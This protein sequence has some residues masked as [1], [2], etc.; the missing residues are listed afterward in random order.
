MILTSIVS[1]ALACVVYSTLG[2]V[3]LSPSEENQHC[4]DAN[5]NLTR[6]GSEIGAG[7][8]FRETCAMRCRDTNCTAIVSPT[9]SV[10]SFSLSVR[11]L[12]ACNVWNEKK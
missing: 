8:K 11:V 4:D 9:R 3:R 5:A 6:S 10:G 1:E 7:V 12:I 2:F